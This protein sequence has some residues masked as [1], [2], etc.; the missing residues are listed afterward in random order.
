MVHSIDGGVVIES[1]YVSLD[2]DRINLRQ[3][4]NDFVVLIIMNLALADLN[5]RISHG[6]SGR[7]IISEETTQLNLTKGS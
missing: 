1:I 5:K 4:A 3:T 6:K 2:S 7:F